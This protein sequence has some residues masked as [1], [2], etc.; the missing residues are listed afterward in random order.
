MPL[1]DP[2]VGRHSLGEGGLDAHYN[3]S[4]ITLKFGSGQWIDAAEFG[5]IFER[6][7]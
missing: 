6:V 5:I 4:D 3:N 7:K 2:S 1:C